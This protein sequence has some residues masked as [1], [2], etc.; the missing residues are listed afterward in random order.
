MR[1]GELEIDNVPEKEAEYTVE[2]VDLPLY[3]IPVEHTR[4]RLG[5]LALTV[6]AASVGVSAERSRLGAIVFFNCGFG[7]S[8]PPCRSDLFQL[9]HSG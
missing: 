3:S 1:F 9:W 4:R 5:V 8:D 6:D 7:D 2:V